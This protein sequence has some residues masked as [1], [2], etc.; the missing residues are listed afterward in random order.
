MSQARGTGTRMKDEPGRLLH[1][2]IFDDDLA[3]RT[4][5]ADG[6]GTYGFVVITPASEEALFEATAMYDLHCIV[7]DYHLA[8]RTGIEVQA[9]LVGR[10]LSVPVV[11][12]SAC[13]VPAIAQA[14]LNAGAVCFMT[15]PV[16]L[17]DLA[18][19]IRGVRP[20]AA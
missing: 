13:P 20:L 11:F 7:L 5:L 10:G 14:A 16:R 9:R 4:A 12:V 17:K 15:K 18:T 1:V 2:A 6:L 8:D 3:F 19:V